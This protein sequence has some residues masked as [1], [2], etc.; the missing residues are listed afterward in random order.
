MRKRR[1]R[2]PIETENEAAAVGMDR[3][4]R[5]Q[6]RQA[7]SIVEESSGER[8]MMRADR[9]AP[10][11]GGTGSDRSDVGGGS[12]KVRGWAPGGERARHACVLPAPALGRVD[13]IID[14]AT[15]EA[16]FVTTKLLPSRKKRLLHIWT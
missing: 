13:H 16:G 6:H 4:S 5:Y 9:D 1:L 3:R 11:F 7:R 12:G 10:A 8:G 14:C 2:L 15:G